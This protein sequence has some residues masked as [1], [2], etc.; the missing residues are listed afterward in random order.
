MIML[1]VVLQSVFPGKTFSTV[2]T[3]EMLGFSF[4]QCSS[5]RW[6]AISYWKA[7]LQ[8]VQQIFFCTGWAVLMCRFSASPL[9]YVLSQW[10]HFTRCCSS[11]QRFTCRWKW[12]ECL[13][14]T[15]HLGHCFRTLS[16][17]LSELGDANTSAVWNEMRS[18][19]GPTL[20]CFYF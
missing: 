14:Q 9:E 15:P 12:V 17:T 6:R 13:I 3:L 8:M 11:P 20:L 7:F 1:L 18:A 10:W 2:N 19:L 5:W 4:P 16:M